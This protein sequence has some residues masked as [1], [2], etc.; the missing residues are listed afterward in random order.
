MN[1][2]D[3]LPFMASAEED[4]GKP[5]R[6]AG[7]LLGNNPHPDPPASVGMGSPL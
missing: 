2:I 6:R 5:P 3:D 7:V 4:P 1:V